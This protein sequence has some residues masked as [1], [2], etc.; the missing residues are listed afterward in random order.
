MILRIG[1]ILGETVRNQI[2]ALL[3]RE[4]LLVVAGSDSPFVFVW[5]TDVAAAFAEA[6]LGPVTGI[7]N[8]AGDGVVTVPEIAA[9]TNRRTLTVP[10]AVLKLALRIGRA[11]RL[12][13]HGPER[14][15]FLQYRPVLDNR[16]L[17]EELGVRLQY[18]SREAFEAYLRLAPNRTQREPSDVAWMHEQ[19]RSRPGALSRGTRQAGAARPRRHPG[20]P[21]TPTVPDVPPGPDIPDVPPIDRSRAPIPT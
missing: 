3:D 6:V 14:V 4:R 10:A 12:T 21:E 1:T 9:M 19:G 15:G 11:L 17:R 16:R 20:R 5:H 18:T 13:E 2:T 7:F 8:V